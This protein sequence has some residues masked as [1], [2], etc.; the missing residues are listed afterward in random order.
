MVC[1]ACHGQDGASGI[2]PSYPNLAGQN[3][4]YLFNQMKMIASGERVLVK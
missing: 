3:E 2:A 1:S 4:K